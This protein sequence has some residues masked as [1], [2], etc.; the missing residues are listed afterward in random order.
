MFF[1]ADELAAVVFVVFKVVIEFADF[2][3][4]GEEGA[5]ERDPLRLPS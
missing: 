3:K 2:F 5:G 4:I 1:E